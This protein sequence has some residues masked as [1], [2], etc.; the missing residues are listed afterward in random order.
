MRAYV[1]TQYGDEVEDLSSSASAEVF[2]F[3]PPA[4]PVP[5]M[6]MAAKTQRLSWFQQ[7]SW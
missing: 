4:A 6:Q 5:R 1:A 2:G 7:F 3:Q